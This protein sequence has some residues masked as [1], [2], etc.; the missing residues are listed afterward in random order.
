M[1]SRSHQY[2]CAWRE[3]IEKKPIRFDV[4][5]PVTVPFTAQGMDL[6][7]RRKAQVRL[8]HVDD[9]LKLVKILPLIPNSP[10]VAFETRS[11]K[12]PADYHTRSRRSRNERYSFKS[13]PSFA[14]LIA[15]IVS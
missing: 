8:E 10:Q 12:K 2:E 7:A 11:S 13:L 9:R 14:S 3:L 4:T 5:I 15:S 1:A 6:A